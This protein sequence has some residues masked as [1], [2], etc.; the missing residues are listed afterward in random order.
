MSK[1]VFISLI[2]S[3]FLGFLSA[4]IVYSKYRDNLEKAKYNTYLIQIGSYENKELIEPAFSEND[5]LVLEEDGK[6]NI[7]V[8]ITTDL[9]NANKIKEIYDKKEIETYIKPAI[10]D[11]IEFVSN[12]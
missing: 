1:R 12:L 10:I 6:Y 9:S 11:N 5:Y 7:Y 2:I 8:G 4:Q 3:V